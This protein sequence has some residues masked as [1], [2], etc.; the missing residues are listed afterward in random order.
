M[1]VE[2]TN[3]I[4]INFLLIDNSSSSIFEC[5]YF[6]KAECLS[7]GNESLTIESILKN[8]MGLPNH[9]RP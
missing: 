3:S 5:A 9:S 8:L 7:Q 1:R 4:R 6:M 2:N